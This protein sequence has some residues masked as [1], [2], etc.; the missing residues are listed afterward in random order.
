VTRVVARDTIGM[1]HQASKGSDGDRLGG[2]QWRSLVAES[3]K[4]R[5][6]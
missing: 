4:V 6:A 2:L 1:D 5:V 3:V